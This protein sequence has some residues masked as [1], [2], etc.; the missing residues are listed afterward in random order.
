ML[1]SQAEELEAV[2][3]DRFHYRT[4]IVELNVATKPQHQLNRHLSA[5]VEANDGPNNLMIVYYTGHGRYQEKGDFL[6]LTA[7]VPATPR[8]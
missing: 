1:V 2:F 3:R 7:Y 8:T 4:Q 6:Q 5:F